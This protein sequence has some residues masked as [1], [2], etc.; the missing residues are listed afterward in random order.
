MQTPCAEHGF[1]FGCC[2]QRHQLEEDLG[3]A[4]TKRAVVESIDSAENQAIDSMK[5]VLVSRRMIFLLSEVDEE[6]VF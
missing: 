5:R 6:S 4:F 2:P 1:Q 3:K